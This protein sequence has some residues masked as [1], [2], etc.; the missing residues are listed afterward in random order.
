MEPIRRYLGEFEA[1]LLSYG[2]PSTMRNYDYAIERLLKF[3]P[4]KTHPRQ[5]D[6]MD[7]QDYLAAR[8]ASGVTE[9]TVKIDVVAIRAFWNWMIRERGLRLSN[10]ASQ[11]RDTFL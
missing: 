7:V 1:W 8:R 11:R 2:R 4:R 3:F 10:P 6:R 5:F 9:G